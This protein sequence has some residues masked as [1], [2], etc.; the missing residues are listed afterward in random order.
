MCF[1][2]I[3]QNPSLSSDPNGHLFFEEIPFQRSCDTAFTRTGKTTQNNITSEHGYPRHEEGES[4][5]KLQ[6]VKPI[7]TGAVARASL[8]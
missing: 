8:S 6:E 1:L 7:L 3:Q 4:K 2:H 5:R